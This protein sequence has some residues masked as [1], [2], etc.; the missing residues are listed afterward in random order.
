MGLV[1]IKDK[2]L[3]SDFWKECFDNQSIWYYKLIDLILSVDRDSKKEKGYEIHHI[4]P[5][6]FFK[7]KNIEIDNS[8]D[9]LIKFTP[10]EHY[11]AHYYMSK[12][13]KK[14]IKR[15]MIYA[16]HLMTQTATTRNCEFSAEEFSKMYEEVKLEFSK[17]QKINCNLKN[18]SKELRYQNLMKAMKTRSKNLEY[19]KYLSERMKGNKFGE[20]K[21][22]HSLDEINLVTQLHNSGFTLAEINR[23]YKIDHNTIKKQVEC[24]KKKYG[25]DK[26]IDFLDLPQCVRNEKYVYN[27]LTDDILPMREAIKLEKIS[28]TTFKKRLNDDDYKYCLIEYMSIADIVEF[29]YVYYVKD[30]KILDRL[31]EILDKMKELNT[32]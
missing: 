14:I 25:A 28:D 10:S 16:L 8:D 32:K 21:L 27:K 31:K 6:S 30:E 17:C 19:R 20:G 4:I 13:A 24:A 11:M 2:I 26:V 23:Y 9:N 5:R 1:L 3:E 15:S 29:L 7:L 12:C 18:I 22:K